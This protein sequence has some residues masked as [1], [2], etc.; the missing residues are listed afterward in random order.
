MKEN[1]K[2]LKLRTLFVIAVAAFCCFL[3]LHSVY[4]QI[5]F[6]LS[7]APESNLYKYG[8]LRC[9]FTIHCLSFHRMRMHSPYSHRVVSCSSSCWCHLWGC[10]ERQIHN[11]HW[12][13][14]TI[15]THTTIPYSTRLF[16]FCSL[17]CVMPSSQL[18]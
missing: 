17:I 8:I 10:I 16:C 6:S 12:I 3:F 14:C 18:K 4:S 15:F 1:S 9:S 11:N 7:A 2:T 5:E 13:P